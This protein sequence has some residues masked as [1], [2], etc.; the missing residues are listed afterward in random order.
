MRPAASLCIY[1]IHQNGRRDGVFI[2]LRLK[3]CQL[4]RSSHNWLFLPVRRH[5]INV[6]SLLFKWFCK[7][8]KIASQCS[9]LIGLMGEW[10]RK[11]ERSSNIKLLYYISLLASLVETPCSAGDPDPIP[12]S[13]RSPGEGNGNPLQCSCLENFTGRGAWRATVHGVAKSWTQPSN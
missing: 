1:L 9:A 12:E 6:S 5:A 3:W 2:F 4:Y 7:T 8:L 10:K 13:E 11:K